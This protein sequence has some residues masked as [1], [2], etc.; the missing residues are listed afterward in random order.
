[1][2]TWFG[3]G[4]VPFAPGTI[5]ALGAFV[6]ALPLIYSG[7]HL[8]PWGFLLLAAFVY[9]PAVAASTIVAKESGT[10]DPQFV[11]VDE[12][13]GQWVTLAGALRY[14]WLS[15]PLAFGL[16]RLFDIWKPWPIKNIE[17]LPWGTG[18]VMDDIMAGIYAALVLFV[19][20]WFNLY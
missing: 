1:M 10:E 13:L 5:G 20:G 14:N 19:L 7:V 15:L 11:V 12:V 6:V 17:K 3:C 18:I 2:A 9:F 16:F 8:Q 4:L